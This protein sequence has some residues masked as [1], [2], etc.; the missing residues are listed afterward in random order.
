[1]RTT[2]DTSLKQMELLLIEMCTL[3]VGALTSASIALVT[4]DRILAEEVAM[5]DD[6][7]NELE[8]QIDGICLSILLREQPFARDLRHVIAAM[9]MVTDMERI[10]DQA[11]NIAEILMVSELDS[12]IEGVIIIEEMADKS[13]KMVSDSIRAFVSRDIELTRKIIEAD[14]EIDNLYEEVKALLIDKSINGKEQIP[15]K[16]IDSIM[17]TKYLERVADHATNVA[18]WVEFA[19][20]GVHPSYGN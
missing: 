6:K 16:T 13:C 11:A 17:I 19:I 18:E 5:N 12:K 20:T 7:I 3:C 15:N 14:D 10:G 9:K 2:I 1:M 4:R 8:S